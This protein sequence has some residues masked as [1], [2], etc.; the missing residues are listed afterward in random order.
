MVLYFEEI[1]WLSNYNSE[2][3]AELKPF[4]DD[5]WRHEKGLKLIICGS[6]PSFI[7]GQ[8]MG[9]KALY[10]R[11]RNEFHLK[12]FSLMEIKD[13]FKRLG[14]REVM[15]AQLTIGGVPEYLKIL[16]KS[17]SLLKSICEHSFLPDS[18]FV[19]VITYDEIFDRRNW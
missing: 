6:S 11:A 4:W 7:I 13:F 5:R 17:L 9:D 14:N 1:Q 3:P 18:Y 19:H 8:L 2:F 16:N 15:L 12:P 10:S